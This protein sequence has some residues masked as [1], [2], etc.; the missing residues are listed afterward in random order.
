M[1][2]RF[3]LLLVCACFLG[4]CAALPPDKAE[5]AVQPAV[6]LPVD[7]GGSWE[8]DYSRD[9]DV[10]ATLQ[11]AYNVL[12][13][14]LADQQRT[15]SPARTG[16]SSNEARS[17]VAL[18]RL[19]EMITRPD[20]LRITTDENVMLVHRGDDFSLTCSF[21]G[22]KPRVIG[23]TFGAERCFVDNGDLVS[24]M[25][26][27]GGLVIVTRFSVSDDGHQLRVITTASSPDSRTPF[28]LNR[29]YR[30]F[31]EPAPEYRCVETLSMKRVC[32]TG[33]LAL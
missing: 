30:R 28:S 16:I 11:R 9:D 26:L 33:E 10:N 22:G 17:L 1:T 19:V 8:R 6:E 32:S 21:A 2:N 13:K 5:T 3:L 27:K 20:V 18:A 23:G 12:A 15:G 14:S 29:F 25:G 7:I 31:E 24:R 4:A